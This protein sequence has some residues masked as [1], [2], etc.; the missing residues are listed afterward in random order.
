MSSEKRRLFPDICAIL[1][2][3]NPKWT[4]TD[5]A[6]SAPKIKKFRF[7]P[8]MGKKRTKKEKTGRSL[9]SLWQRMKDSNPHERSQSPVCYHYTNPLYSQRGEHHYYI[10]P[11]QIVKRKKRKMQKIFRM[12][13][14]DAPLPRRG[15]CGR[16]SPRRYLPMLRSSSA[17]STS[18]MAMLPSI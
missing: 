17:V 16:S 4:K 9:S 11:P 8:Q 10:R 18:T 14:G 3:K 6:P 7:P 2:E 13:G 5:S 1:A 15:Q 12:A